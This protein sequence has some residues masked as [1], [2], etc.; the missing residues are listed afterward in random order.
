MFG[1]SERLGGGLECDEGFENGGDGPIEGGG[2]DG[3]FAVGGGGAGGLFEPAEQPGLV[4]AGD[5]EGGLRQGGGGGL[6]MD[7]E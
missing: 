7:L 6:E 1:G 4:L 3:D 5:G 2:A